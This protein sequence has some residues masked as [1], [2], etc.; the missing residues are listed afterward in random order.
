MRVLFDFIPNHTSDKNDWFIK[1]VNREDPYTDFYI[2]RDPK[3]FDAQ[4]QPIPPNNWLSIFNGPAWRWNEKRRQFY[5]TLFTAAQPDLNYRNPKVRSAMEAS[6]HDFPRIATR[7]EPE[8]SEAASM[9]QLMLPGLASI[10]YGQEIGMTDVR[11]RADQRQEDNGRDG[12][13]GPMQWDESL[14]SGFTTNK[15]AWLPVNPEYW[16]HN[17]KEQLKDPLSHLNIFKRLLE[18]RHNPVIKNGELETCVISE[19]MFLFA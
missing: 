14:N 4:N 17:V 13:R 18:L 3:G 7:V 12:C 9:I 6:T 8:F 10:Y 5:Y 16:R 15:K 2:W 11:I 1:S 19:W